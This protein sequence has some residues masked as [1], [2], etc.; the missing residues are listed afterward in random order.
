MTD[1]IKNIGSA[2]TPFELLYH[3]NIGY[4]LLSENAEITIPSVCVSA[5]NEHA[6]DG[7]KDCL[8]AQKPQAGYEEKCYYH[9]LIGN[10]CVSVYNPDIDKC[11]SM[12]YN[13][14]ELRYFTQWKM[15]G[16]YDY[17]MGLEP[18]N[19]HPDGRNVMRE[20]G[21]LEFL[22]PGEEKIYDIT[23]ELKEKNKCL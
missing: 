3:C 9:S 5:R 18:G 1:K 4:P 15:M 21:K 20:Q 7:I 17:V 11:L 19:C 23:F 6:K 12:Y 22:E 2:K 8:K 10:T 13:A 16:E 14:D